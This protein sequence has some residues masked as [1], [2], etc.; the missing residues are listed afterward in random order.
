[1]TQIV[2]SLRATLVLLLLTGLLYP[3]A[4]TAAAQVLVPHQANGSLVVR[5]GCVVGS[6]L[7]GQ[8]FRSPGYFHPRPSAAGDG[9]DAMASGAT[10]LG[11][12]SS[13]LLHGAVDGSFEGV[14]QLAARV[15]QENG[16]AVDAPVPVDAVTRSASGLDPHI[17]VA[18]AL[19]QVPR[20]ARHRGLD[21]ATVA[22]IVRQA[23]EGRTWGMLGEPRV[24]VL[25]ANLALDRAG[26]HP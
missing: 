6:E 2:V 10:N 13:R 1:M 18:H 14:A 20:V 9:Y 25:R 3:L 8:P 4:V 22:G 5:E 21:E 26:A 24:N 16:L 15:R 23:T 11:P 19:L 12:S 17:S 7:I